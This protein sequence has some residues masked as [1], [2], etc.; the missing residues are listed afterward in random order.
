M[1]YTRRMELSKLKIRPAV[2]SDLPLIVALVNSAYRGASGE[3]GWTTETKY[4]GGQRTDEN[5]LAITFSAE[6]S[7]ILQ[8][9]DSEKLIA[10][11]HLQKNKGFAY[12]GMLTVDPMIQTGGL[13]KFLLSSA[14]AW[15]RLNWSSPKIEMTVLNKRGELIAWYERRGYRLTDRTEPFPYDDERFGIPKIPDL[16]FV[17]LEKFI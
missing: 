13:G 3:R 1:R 7:V 11:V 17:V 8:V 2:R 9:L 5:S 16:S 10:C 4:L 6:G 15:A 14:E 12:L